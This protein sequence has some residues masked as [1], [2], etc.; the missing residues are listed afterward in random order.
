MLHV[1]GIAGLGLGAIYLVWLHV[2]VGLFGYFYASESIKAV[3]YGEV[4]LSFYIFGYYVWL[5]ARWKRL[6]QNQEE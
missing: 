5:L 2:M 6:L 3:I 4:A 1:L